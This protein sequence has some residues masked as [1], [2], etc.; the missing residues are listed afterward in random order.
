MEP[1]Q[2]TKVGIHVQ[3]RQIEVPEDDPFKNDLLDRREAVE[4]LTHLISNLEGP[5]VL[6]I[7]APWGAGKTTFLRMWTQHLRNQ[8][9]PVV[10][11]NAWETDYCEE[12]FVTLCE[13]LTAGLRVE[14]TK[15]SSEKTKKLK[16]ASLDVLRL[17]VP[18]AIRFATSHVPVVGAEAGQFAASY[19]EERLSRYSKAGESVKGFRSALQDMAGALSKANGNLPLIVAIDELDRCR[20]TYAIELLEVAKH[21]FAVDHVVFVLAV[22]CDQLAHSVRV[23]YGND[24]DAEGYLKRFFDVDCQLPEPGRDAFIRTQLQAT[25]IEDYFDCSPAT[26]S[27]FA[28]T[29]FQKELRR[30]KS[31][32][33]MREMLLMFFGV[34]DLSLRTVGQAIHRLGLLYATLRGDQEDYGMATTVA[35]VL[36][37]LDGKIYSR[38]VNGEAT[39]REVIDAVFDRPSLKP[40]RLEQWSAIFETVVILAALENIISNETTTDNVRSPLLDWYRDHE[41]SEYA[42]GV[43]YGVE[44]AIRQGNAHIGFGEAVRRLELVS[45]TLVET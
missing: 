16:D 19:A 21:L 11:F 23:L 32:E 24:F 6:A 10:E 1:V 26:K 34:S 30:E 36:R 2:G 35:L 5:C 3:L 22:N 40:L 15:P 18:G 39:D 41:D 37:T 4:T 33:I 8:R 31:G 43:V 7:N 45:A 28:N 27:P 25:G 13:E 42:N 44:L 38:F 20:P 14:G 29:Y 9:F 17:V 12:P